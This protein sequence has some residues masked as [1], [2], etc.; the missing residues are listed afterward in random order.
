MP[1][2]QYTLQNVT[3]PKAPAVP[4]ASFI[5]G[6]QKICLCPSDMELADSHEASGM[7]PT[8][9]FRAVYSQDLEVR[10]I[11]RRMTAFAAADWF[12]T[13]HNRGQENTLNISQIRSL[14]LEMPAAA[15]EMLK[16]YSITGD[17]CGA[18]SFMP[19]EEPI[20]QDHPI[21]L[22]PVGGRPSNGSFPFFDI[23]GE[24]EGLIVAIGWSGQWQ[25]AIER[26]DQS[27]NICA[28][29]QDANFYLKPGESARAPRILIMPWAGGWDDAH[30]RFRKLMRDYFSPK[31][32]FGEGFALPAALQEFCRYFFFSKDHPEWVTEEGQI[33]G[34]E[35]AASLEYLDTFWMDALW[36]EGGFPEGVGNYRFAAGYPRGLKPIADAAHRNGLKYIVWFEPERA[37][38]GT[39]VY[40]NSDPSWLIEL[41]DHDF[42]W[43]DTLGKIGPQRL[44]NLGNPETRAW[45]TSLISDFIEDNGV[46]IY[47][48]DMNMDPLEF[49]RAA[50]EEN[51][52]GLS[53]IKYVE[54][55]YQFWDDLLAR[56]PR[57]YIDNCAS[58]G[59]RIDLETCM[60]SVPLWR[61]D[62]GSAPR[63]AEMPKDL[64]NQNQSICLSPYIPYHC[65][66]NWSIVPYEFRSAMTMGT[67]AEFDVL[68]E[69]FDKERAKALLSEF[70]RLQKYWSGDYYALTRPSPGKDQWAAY[71]LD[72]RE[73]DSGAAV[74]FRREESPCGSMIF[75]LRGLEPD[76]RYNLT[77]TG[78]NL[79]AAEMEA[80]GRE[81][82]E[83]M[84]FCIPGQKESLVV[85]YRALTSSNPA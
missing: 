39:D 77:L 18:E 1:I 68:S 72:S 56:F 40:E 62:T 9:E 58:G 19:L 28:G 26:T 60:R 80:S 44:V 78:E 10:L 54:G 34:I 37:A 20:I 29:L 35:L 16:W 32:R 30:N 23:I 75:K 66:N 47:R 11:E 70:R 13:F 84:P 48:Q 59:R 49:W 7:V 15:G 43:E 45:L 4:I 8:N 31:T 5:Y 55:H 27:C 64:W 67:I 71:Q 57:L 17:R 61:S 83:G 41:H 14:D 3:T 63:S 52:K 50:D 25:Y 82:A 73:T 81:M 22:S 51:R 33:H 46:D 2:C 76:H 79:V 6:G 74:L 21:R 53:E 69:S 24:N 12:L 36:F 85:E 65:V 42:A 38:V